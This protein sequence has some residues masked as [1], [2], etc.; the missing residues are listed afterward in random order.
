MV[1]HKN[2][3]IWARSEIHVFSVSNW[4]SSP[5][6]LRCV[7]VFQNRLLWPQILICVSLAMTTS[8]PQIFHHHE[9]H[10]HKTYFFV[11]TCH[12]YCSWG[13]N[14]HDGPPVVFAIELS[15]E[16]PFYISILFDISRVYLIR[17][18]ISKFISSLPAILLLAVYL[19]DFHKKFKSVH[20]FYIHPWFTMI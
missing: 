4:F 12:L 18:H 8:G 20:N 11:A 7:F 3:S 6:I 19:H 17:R 2:N 15:N 10:F 5:L 1:F 16:D 13:H 14:C 9:K